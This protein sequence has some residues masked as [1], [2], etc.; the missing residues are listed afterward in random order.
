MSDRQLTEKQLAE[1]YLEK[2][3]IGFVEECEKTTG[4]R[5]SVYDNGNVRLKVSDWFEKIS[6]IPLDVLED[7]KNLGEK[8]E[9][10]GHHYLPS[11]LILVKRQRNNVLAEKIVEHTDKKLTSINFKVLFT[12][13]LFPRLDYEAKRQRKLIIGDGQRLA[14][15]ACEREHYALY[16]A[17]ERVNYEA[18]KKAWEQFEANVVARDK[19]WSE[20]PDCITTDDLM[21]RLGQWPKKS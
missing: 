13:S 12:P 15:S 4:G 11:S 21:R 16:D 5:I 18:Q 1:A 14:I 17:I 10:D 19:L 2:V 6:L 3:A 9:I 8:I 20:H 7:K